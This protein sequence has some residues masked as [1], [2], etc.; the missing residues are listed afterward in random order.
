M[1]GPYCVVLITASGR[2]EAEKLSRTLVSERLAA[3]V[4]TVPAI[5]SRYWWKGKIETSG[6]ALLI[7][8]TRA[9]FVKKL[10]RRV[11][12]V[13]SYTVPEVIALPIAAGN[14]EYLDWVGASLQPPK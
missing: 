10:V 4:S 6:E 1:P 5:H 9:S 14:P 12:A 11:R 2:R 13:H 3:C 8:K 7:V